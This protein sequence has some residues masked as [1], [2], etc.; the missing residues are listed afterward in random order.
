[1]LQVGG[2]ADLGKEPV[3]ADD[4][5]EL[6]AKHLERHLAVVP[7]VVRE[8]D[9]GHAALPKLTL[10]AVAAREGSAQGFH[11]IT[12]HRC[13]QCYRAGGVSEFQVS[14]RYFH[15]PSACFFS[16]PRY[17]PLSTG[18]GLAP[19]AFGVMTTL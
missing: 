17:L 15:D 7:D 6:G 8:V 3:G 18:S 2:G 10:D 12:S 1:M 5:G 11:R 14:N 19:A 16:T 9:G 4:G 13:R